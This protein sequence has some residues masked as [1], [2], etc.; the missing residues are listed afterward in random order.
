MDETVSTTKVRIVTEGDTAGIEKIDAGLNKLDE[1]VR[2]IDA[3][4][5]VD[6]GPGQG[7]AGHGADYTHDEAS[8]FATGEERRLAIA[9][10]RVEAEA[11]IAAEK[12]AQGV[13]QA[14]A[15]ALESE[16]AAISQARIALVEATVAGDE[17][18]VEKLRQELL[19]RTAI[20][21]QL[22]SQTLSQA[23]LTELAATE[24]RLLVQSAAAVEAKAAAEAAEAEAG[25]ERLYGRMGRGGAILRN[26]GIGMNEV[27][28]ASIGVFLG[29]MVKRWI[30]EWTE[31]YTKIAGIRDKGSDALLKDEKSYTRQIAQLE[32]IR[33]SHSDLG[34]TL[35]EEQKIREK[36][37]NEIEKLD[38]K[39]RELDNQIATASGRKRDTLEAES[40]IN[41]QRIQ[42][43][44]NELGILDA[45]AAK[46]TDA[47]LKS[48][49]LKDAV[50]EREQ[51][52]KLVIEDLNDQA[53]LDIDRLDFLKKQNDLIIENALR[54]VAAEE[55]SGRIDKDEAARRKAA[56]E[57]ERAHTDQRVDL[58]KNAR[59][60]KAAFDEIAVKKQFAE[61]REAEFKAA[62][63]RLTRLQADNATLEGFNKEHVARI[64]KAREDA[65]KYQKAAEA[66]SLLGLSGETDSD[67]VQKAEALKKQAE[68]SAYIAKGAQAAI[69]V[70]NS[71]I[72]SNKAS[73]EAT[74]A[75]SKQSENQKAQADLEE[76]NRKLTARITLLM[77]Q[78]DEA[79]SLN[80]LKNGPL[81]EKARFAG[82]TP[83]DDITAA[84]RA[85]DLAG[86]Q[87]MRSAD[88]AALSRAAEMLRGAHDQQHEADAI[89]ALA[90]AV[91]HMHTQLT[92]QQ[93]AK[94][95]PLWDAI[96]AIQGQL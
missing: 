39:Q 32:T 45:H 5:G 88:V 6:A 55:K 7:S 58:E 9:K 8:P 73:I 71:M 25:P 72:A 77:Q 56:L 92:A 66:V 51:I 68:K 31:A 36:I 47:A 69:N 76:T 67:E 30:D 38:D 1:K 93:E 16:S 22:K 24:E 86:A 11:E 61:E 17:A 4:T 65:A 40:E 26:F 13:A 87:G 78:A 33:A 79:R 12:K 28:A 18:G 70:N 89:R 80:A 20:A 60:Q 96:H 37:G 49:A 41:G 62:A 2:I 29:E 94:L 53:K 10:A 48:Q 52:E 83:Q 59:E 44:Q 43:L 85:R 57:D 14:Q 21:Q 64:A 63:E 54:Q 90:D 42:S 74:D 50:K 23:E 91:T 19:I 95:K 15:N 3:S 75:G 81:D 82:G 46:I 27:I 84:S 34:K 35:E